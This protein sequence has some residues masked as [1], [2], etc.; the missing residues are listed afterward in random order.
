[1]RLPW[2]YTHAE[3]VASLNVLCFPFYLRNGL[4]NTPN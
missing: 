1:M 2:R 3:E 4:A